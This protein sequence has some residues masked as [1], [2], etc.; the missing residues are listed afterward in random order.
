MVEL[1]FNLLFN[2]RRV[3]LVRGFVNCVAKL[4]IQFIFALHALLQLSPGV[5]SEMLLD[6]QGFLMTLRI[7]LPWWL[8]MIVRKRLGLDICCLLRCAGFY[9]LLGMI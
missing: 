3:G 8:G 4:R 7:P 2:L 6:G 5:F 1:G 9:G